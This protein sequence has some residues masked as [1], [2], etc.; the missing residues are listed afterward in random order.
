MTH[1]HHLSVVMPVFNAM[2]HLDA[3]VRSILD[4]TYAGFEFV[5]FDDGSTDGSTERLRWWASQENRI[6]LLESSA[7]LGPARRSN[8]AVE[9]A[10]GGLIAQ[11]HVDR[12]APIR[13]VPPTQIEAPE[14]AKTSGSGG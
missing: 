11:E 10:S 9:L 13:W 5:I 3:A 12:D 8:R 14:L 6:I 2:P 7:N 4:Q 1:S